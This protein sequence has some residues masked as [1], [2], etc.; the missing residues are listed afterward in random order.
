MSQDYSFAEHGVEFVKGFLS[1]RSIDE[2][3]QE[4][5]VLYDSSGMYGMRNADKKIPTIHELAHSELLLDKAKYYLGS[6]AKLVRAILFDKTPDK[7][8]LVTWHQD[9]TI[10]VTQKLEIPGWGP[11]SIKDGVIHV[12]P[13]VEVLESMVTFRIHLDLA[14]ESTGCLK[15]VPKSHVYGILNDQ[16]K[17]ALVRNTNHY[18]CAAN[19]GDMLVMRPHL[20]HA[21]SKAS[22]PSHRRIV[23]LEY[24]SFSLPR[25]LTWA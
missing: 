3:L 20:L 14:D 10:A 12:Q 16:S 18:I 13:N 23:H 25:G 4:L 24:S 6:D 22:N 11:W 2:I 8:W 15:I 9:K 21:S 17:A 5:N 7:N 1:S 19:P